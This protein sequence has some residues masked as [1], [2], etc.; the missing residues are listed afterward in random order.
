VKKV[1][2]TT[3]VNTGERC[4]SPRITFLAVI[5]AIGMLHVPT[6]E[7]GIKHVLCDQCALSSWMVSV[8]KRA[9]E[10]RVTV[11]WLC[12]AVT[13]QLPWSSLPGCLEVA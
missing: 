12:R 11:G 3:C 8:S 6:Q 9:L 4:H 13:G 5:P 7:L 10:V 1:I 2:R